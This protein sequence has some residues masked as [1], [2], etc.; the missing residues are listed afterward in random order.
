[1][2]KKIVAIAAVL[3]LSLISLFGCAGDKYDRIKIDG[4]QDTAQ[5]VTS[6]GGSAVGYGNYV[7]FLNGTRGYEDTE[8]KS[9]VFGDV[10][11][12]AVYRAEILKKNSDGSYVIDENSV[13]VMGLKAHKDEDYKRDETEV[14]DVER[15]APKTVGTSGYKGGGIFIFGDCLYYAS[16]NNLKSKTGEV[17]HLKTDFFRMTLDGKTTQK[18]YTTTEDTA[19][20]PYMFFSQGDYVYLSVLDGTDLISVKINKKNGKKE[21]TLKIAEDVT[22]AVMPSKPV[23][24]KDINENSIYDFIFFERA[25]TGDDVT[26]SGEVLEFVRPDGTSRTIF[27][28]SSGESYTLETVKDGYLFYRKAV[29]HANC[30]VARNMHNELADADEAYKNEQKNAGIEDVQKTVLRTSD[31]DNLTLYPFVPNYEFG[32]ATV[33]NSIYVLTTS[34]EAA[35][36]LYVDGVKKNTIA[37]GS[38][39][40][41]DTVYGNDIFY[42][43]DGTLNKVS[44]AAGSDWTPVVIAENVTSGT[45]GA[46]VAG[47][48]LIYFAN[49]ADDATGYAFF[50]ELDGLQIEDRDSAAFVGELTDEEK[51]SKTE[52]LTIVEQPTKTQY[53]VGEK[54]DLKGLVVEAQFY[55][56]SEGNR[57][58]N[59]TVD[60]K[61]DMISGFDS[62]AAGDVTVTITY[63]KKTAT[64][65]VTVVGDENTEQNA[66]NGE[67]NSSCSTVAPLSPWFFIGGGGLM[68]LAV[69]ALFIGKRKSAQ[70]A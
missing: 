54:L 37:E 4:V 66:E 17:Q 46:D 50:Y 18:I 13:A 12:G 52:S 25:A 62:S 61:D 32:A 19:T 30:L 56:D 3:A 23:Y 47:G 5:T 20:S 22:A 8:A 41:V 63:D 39:I 33:S 9:N 44:F 24:Y 48:Y 51:P 65:N 45:Y 7:Y 15:I 2:F 57:P 27:E 60:V 16:P 55:A 40:T 10:V 14:V 59:I 36:N 26:Q 21:D 58:D 31:I 29:N 69:G 53:K 43:A 67:N 42:T 11:K 35:L 64:F 1:M 28:A 38:S 34:T 49:V 70:I 6:N 68:I